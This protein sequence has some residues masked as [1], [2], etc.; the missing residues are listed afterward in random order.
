LYGKGSWV[1]ITG[2]SDGIGYGFAQ[3]LA[4]L[5]FNMVLIARNKKKLKDT[6]IFLAG[7]YKIEVI[8][9]Q[10]DFTKTYESDFYDEIMEKISHLD[11]SIL[12]NNVG[13]AVGGGFL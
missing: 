10:K 4:K 9:I 1:V 12:V 2:G 8:T 11:V 7:R 5:G 13:T 3:E 6:A